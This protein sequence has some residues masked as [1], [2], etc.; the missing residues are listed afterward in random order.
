MTQQRV[1]FIIITT[2]E[3]VGCD[4]TEIRGNVFIMLVVKAYHFEGCERI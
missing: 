3:I 2:N 1:S 4:I